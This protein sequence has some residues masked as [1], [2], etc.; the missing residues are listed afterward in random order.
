MPALESG[1]AGAFGAMALAMAGEGAGGGAGDEDVGGD[2]GEELDVGGGKKRKNNRRGSKK[3]VK[4]RKVG[5]VTLHV[6]SQTSAVSRGPSCFVFPPV[7]APAARGCSGAVQ[8]HGCITDLSGQ[9]YL[10]RRRIL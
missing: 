9:G 10:Q 5:V 8:S 7:S 6:E 3:A 4:K 1:G 2:E